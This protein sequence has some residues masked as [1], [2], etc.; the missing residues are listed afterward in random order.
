MPVLV[1][2]VFLYLLFRKPAAQKPLAIQVPMTADRIARG[3]YIFTTL[4]SCDDCHSE[5]DFKKLGGPVTPMGRGKGMVMP[6]NGLPGVI[7]ASNI[8]PDSETG[9]GNWTD[10]EKIR[11]IR[12][13]VSKDGRALFP[14]MP[15]ESY[16]HLSDV[17][18]QALVAYMN[19]LPPIRNPLPKT[20]VSF[21]ASMLIKSVPQ[22][23]TSVD[24][25]DP[26]G[27]EIYGDYLVKIAG[28]EECH[29]PVNF[30]GS[31]RSFLRFA[32]GRVFDTPYGKVASANITPDEETGIGSWKFQQFRDRMKGWAHYETDGYP[33]AAPER[34]TLMPWISYARISEHDLESI[35]LYLKSVKPVS[36]QVEVHPK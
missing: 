27:G 5:R 2:G 11:A 15:Y 12:D 22:P 14:L 16:R 1:L 8:T 19:T 29:T 7:V 17:D 21:P 3:E 4:A 9:I 30:M 18:V 25:A 20:S 33:N 26:D 13:G 35:Y 31:P 10:G 23:V 32:G 28:C 6:L 24:W 34:F 36:N